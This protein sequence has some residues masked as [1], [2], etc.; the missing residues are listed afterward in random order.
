MWKTYHF[1]FPASRYF[2]TTLTSTVIP[3]RL[4]RRRSLSPFPTPIRVSSWSEAG[5]MESNSP[6]GSS[7]LMCLSSL[8]RNTRGPTLSIGGRRGI[9]IRTRKN[10]AVSPV[11]PASTSPISFQGGVISLMYHIVVLKCLGIS[12]PDLR[13][14]HGNYSVEKVIL[15]SHPASPRLIRILFIL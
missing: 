11:S 5:G 10:L 2:P 8:L 13:L 15:L 14:F 4:A 6:R 3:S 9:G 1:V 7:S 12:V